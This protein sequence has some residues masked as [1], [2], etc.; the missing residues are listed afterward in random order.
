MQDEQRTQAGYGQTT[1]SEQPSTRPRP[2]S[3]IPLLALLGVSMLLA[4]LFWLD[5]IAHPGAQAEAPRASA[6]SPLVALMA[7]GKLAHAQFTPV[8][9]EAQEP[10]APAKV[11]SPVENATVSVAA[12][13]FV[14]EDRRS[15]LIAFDQPLGKGK[16]GPIGGPAPATLRPSHDGSWSWVSPS[17]LK[18]DSIR[19]LRNKA[20]YTVTF[21]T[22][23]LL[24]EGKRWA[25]GNSVSIRTGEFAVQRIEL[26]EEINTANPREVMLHGTA[27]FTDSVD[28][29]AFLKH[30]TLQDAEG[31]THEVALQD[32]W[33]TSH[34]DFQAGPFEK[35]VEPKRF[36]ATIT[37]GLTEY[38]GELDL[39]ESYSHSITVQHDKFWSVTQVFGEMR[40]T[41]PVITLR[42]TAPVDRGVIQDAL[43]LQPTAAFSVA[44]SQ[45]DV[46]LSGDFKPGTNYSL[47]LP[48]GLVALN[49]ATLRN[50]INT[51]VAMPPLNPF[52]RFEGNGL[53]LSKH[54]LRTLSLE[55]VNLNETAINVDRVYRSNLVLLLR[56]YHS[57]YL[58]DDRSYQDQIHDFLGDR[59]LT[60]NMT[61]PGEENVISRT[62]VALEPLLP[63]GEKG[64]FR[65]TAQSPHSRWELAQRWVLMTDIGLVAKLGVGELTV[66][67]ASVDN[68][69]AL[70]GVTLTLLDYQNQPIAT[71]ITDAQGV[72]KTALEYQED[73]VK[74]PFL[75][76]AEKEDD[77]SLLLFDQFR[78]D[79]TGQD[80]GGMAVARA[81]YT[82]FLYGE[83]D[84]Y[85]P[86]ETAHGVA[87]LRDADLGT[88]P[89]MPVILVH[90]DPRGKELDK[91]VLTTRQNGMLTFDL[92]IPSFAITG[93]YRVECWVADKRV[94]EYRY[95]VEEFMP[96]R[97]KVDI[98]S[99]DEEPE[100]GEVLPFTVDSRFLFGAPASKLPVNAEVRLRAQPFA[101]EAMPQYD[102][103]NNDITFNEQQIFTAENNLNDEGIIELNASIPQGVRPPAA[104]EA[105]ISA[106]VREQGGRGVTALLSRTVHAY[107][108]YV[109]VKRLESSGVAP[110]SA[111]TFDYVLVDPKGAVVESNASLKAVIWRD[112]W[113]TVLRKTPSG[114]FKY[115]SE[116]Q[117]EPM[118]EVHLMAATGKGTF[119]WVPPRFGSYRVVISDTETGASTQTSFYAGGWGYSPW[120]VANPATLELVPDKEEYKPGE[121]ATIQIRAPF[122]GRLLVTVE[123]DR[124][125]DMQL[126]PM[127]GNTAT[128]S[129]QVN[130]SYSP[131]VYVSAIVVRKA[132][133]IQPGMVGRA[134]GWLPLQVDRTANNPAVAIDV[135]EMMRPSTPLTITAQ[136]LPNAT[137]TLAAVDEGI[138]QLISQET[139][140]PFPH[141][142][143]KR[144]LEVESYDTFA[145]LLP[146][147]NPT[148]GAS[149][150]GG[151]GGDAAG[152][153]V[154]T[155]ALRRVVPVRFWSGPLQTD[156]QG[157]VE[158]TIDIPEFNGALRVMAVV[159]QAKQFGSEEAFVKVRAPIIVSAT[160]P[161]FLSLDETIK[162]PVSVR[163]DVG[164]DAAFEVA[165]DMQ[166]PVSANDLSQSL[167]VPQ[168]R[169][170]LVYFDVMTS[171]NTG[172]LQAVVTA[173]TQNGT[174]TIT[175]RET[176]AL[177]IRSPLPPK[178][179]VQS[180]GL[181]NATTKL[182]VPESAAFV[183]GS[184]KRELH[185]SRFPLMRFAA[186]LTNV[187]RYPYGCLEQ[188]TSSTFPL[189]Y[190]GEMAAILE[191]ERFKD[192]ST[193]AQVQQGIRRIQT[194]QL[195]DGSFAM[196]PGSSDSWAWA[197]V[198]ATHFLLEA[199]GA[200]YNVDFVLGRALG[201]LQ[202]LL[203]TKDTGYSSRL[204]TLAYA[205]FVLAKAGTPDHGAMDYLQSEY[206][207]RFSAE[208]AALLGGAY[209]M[210][211][212][213][214][215]LET[216]MENRWGVQ[217]VERSTGG[218]LDSTIGNLALRILV[219]QDSLPG[220]R[221][222]AE[223]VQALGREMETT[224]YY[225]TQEN[226]YAFLALGRFFRAQMEKGSIAG[227]VYNDEELVGSFT[228][229]EP[230]S[231]AGP[232]ALAGE[233]VL[234]IVLES[235]GT[236]PEN[237]AY[238]TIY[239]RG[240]PVLASHA[241]RAEGIEITREFFTQDGKPL[242]IESATLRQGDLLVMRV[243]VKSTKG[244]INNVAVETLLPAG[245][246]VEN[247]RLT[248]SKRL[249]W[250]KNAAKPVYQDIRDDRVIS[251]VDLNKNGQWQQL[252]AMLRAVTPGTFQLPPAHAEAMYDP[253]LVATGELS[254]IT[255]QTDRG[256][257]TA[258][259]EEPS[260]KTAAITPVLPMGGMVQA[261][262][263]ATH[264]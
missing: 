261:M 212:E 141:F 158:W 46:L 252:Y 249:S 178:T 191:P 75:L 208:V 8:R 183:R 193:A 10:A 187:L 56:Q 108:R 180:G 95:Q 157:K 199:K 40:G 197:S 262:A 223:L 33:R 19:H 94:G 99:P 168:G 162:I 111:V 125:H 35:T 160:F 79:Q 23:A 128:V 185:V 30:F 27:I 220:D 164:Q 169:E 54:G 76:L 103:G 13:A 255:V 181:S 240:Q 209:A 172:H 234:R 150:A 205:A 201:Y 44:V 48:E 241:P 245:V 22:D 71:G 171:E 4:T 74:Q 87:L 221:R 118:E 110:G 1:S 52:L 154:R 258:T 260:N 106:R 123:K 189:L 114:S 2:A 26:R 120:A 15:L 3:R 138:L 198:Y 100:A 5:T 73:T 90:K 7:N 132:G 192:V 137:I 167:E 122:G 55:H 81:G 47:K 159:N 49:G 86:G 213:A 84:L 146:E 134:S 131:N 124:V 21:S 210:A 83:R 64:L 24:P 77:F 16:L 174:E 173:S 38:S 184:V 230:L 72:W 211:G 225:T 155:D 246:E 217:Q 31:N 51:S 28:P 251:F 139:P 126:H 11:F 190:F 247:P 250:V 82:A 57:G 166:G 236:I 135:P 176:V 117:S 145:M 202:Q 177:P 37:P 229:Q 67:S 214:G 62:P 224:P 242:D 204:K 143:A 238:Y 153:S 127:E 58:V 231:L 227:K 148:E 43:Q 39:L 170:R 259:D 101:V 116:R 59:L 17:V 228:D 219:L 264:Q 237:A 65:I 60:R 182:A 104:L 20:R 85:R 244:T 92:D 78:I 256:D 113:H 109:G 257:G 98:F 243:K 45:K 233:G 232:D 6:S 203:K 200:G 34:L 175:G 29:K 80:V 152:K 144:A 222:V 218:A 66:S 129:F 215:A 151:D 195:S 226:C 161:R 42:V 112:R 119:T 107:S 89:P 133:D 32:T 216:L 96:D 136:T 149:P 88:P 196:W 142:Y 130:E 36:T 179:L 254:T 53:F 235:D 194:M 206:K 9:A 69:E 165:L 248:T 25:D 63:E 163:N 41:Q 156:A 207:K 186:N 70:E 263:Q 50:G 12:V 91:M 121:T 97:I 140:D 18:F 253:G 102:F 14:G 61:L 68:L 239:T 188:T 93:R 147:V 105:V 115:D